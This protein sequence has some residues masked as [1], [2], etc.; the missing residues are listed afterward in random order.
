LWSLRRIGLLLLGLIVLPWLP[1]CGP[2]RHARPAR[3]IR[4]AG[5]API[6]A[7]VFAPDGATIASIQWD[8]RVALRD[9]AGGVDRPSFLDYGGHARA[10]A[11]SPDGRSLAVGGS[12][13]GIRLYAI[14]AGEAGRPVGMP[15][16]SVNSLVLS[17]D[18]R[19]VAASSNLSEEILLWDLAAGREHARL[20]G[21]GSP[22][23]SLAFAPDGRSLASGSQSD[24]AILLWDLATSRPGRRL[25]VPPRPVFY[26]VYSPDGRWLASICHFERPVRL[27]DLEGRREE[28]LIGSHSSGSEPV[29]FSPDGRMLATA[30]DEGV[31]RL[32]DPATGAELHRVGGS[33]DRLTGVAFS[34]DGR[35]LA[36]SGT[37]SDIRLW[38]LADLLGAEIPGA[39]RA[40]D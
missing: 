21:H 17:P 11:F 10:L 36:A 5:Y 26:L 16:R 2:P 25:G 15:I 32:W 6:L 12:E 38:P 28:R 7:F 24:G 37:D 40:T 35:L 19:L 9:A 34:P 31:V 4:G 18:G 22:V 29:A 1:I 30:G 33:A 27:W 13:P 39:L 8:G 20:R 23:I 3:R 14:G